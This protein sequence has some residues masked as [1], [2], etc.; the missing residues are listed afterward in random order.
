M[1]RLQALHKSLSDEMAKEVLYL[2][3]GGAEG[4]STYRTSPDAFTVTG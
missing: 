3:G 1:P 4:A 2:T